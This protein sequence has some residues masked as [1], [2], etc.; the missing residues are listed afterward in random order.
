MPRAG[1]RGPNEEDF[2]RKESLQRAVSRWRRSLEAFSHLSL[3]FPTL[4]AAA[5]PESRRCTQFLARP[6]PPPALLS[7]PV[8]MWVGSHGPPLDRAGPSDGGGGWHGAPYGSRGGGASQYGGGPL[9]HGALQRSYRSTPDAKQASHLGGHS[10]P[11]PACLPSCVPCSH[12]ERR[13]A[14]FEFYAPSGCTWDGSAR[15]IFSLEAPAHRSLLLRR[16]QSLRRCS[17]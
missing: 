16:Q 15:I 10:A 12:A 9:L 4:E 13:Q 3:G 7:R 14:L 2:L 8:R 17:A 5:P 1:I 11:L 6:P